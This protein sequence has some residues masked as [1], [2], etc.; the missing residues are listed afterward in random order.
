MLPKLYMTEQKDDPFFK[1]LADFRRRQ[2]IALLLERSQTT[3]EICD[4]F[5]DSLERT[6]VLKHLK[7]LQQAELILSERKGRE[8]WN[9]FNKAIFNKNSE[10]FISIY[11]ANK[12]TLPKSENI[13]L[14][15]QSQQNA[16]PI[17]KDWSVR[18]VKKLEE[19]LHVLYLSKDLKTV[20]SRRHFFTPENV[21]DRDKHYS[22][23][24][25][26]MLNNL[27]PLF[28]LIKSEIYLYGEY[29]YISLP[30]DPT[31][32]KVLDDERFTLPSATDHA[33]LSLVRRAL[34]LR[35]ALGM[36]S[37][38]AHL[39]W[40]RYPEGN[41]LI[42]SSIYSIMKDPGRGV[43]A[44]KLDKL[45]GDKGMVLC[46]EFGLNTLDDASKW[47]N[48]IM[49]EAREIAKNIDPELTFVANNAISVLHN[50]IRA[51][52][53]YKQSS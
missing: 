19:N 2:M 40:R 38:V 21:I 5:K 7:V 46:E 1:A 4:H 27:S 9:R 22:I 52:I 50:T 30:V 20:Y 39:R 3:G 29:L 14:P 51:Y 41:A 16:Q 6:T 53:G 15:T 11:N 34:L 28:G 42:S 17:P 37:R 47:R 18:R 33:Q 35:W 44:A 32:N 31:T 25:T 12:K 13:A 8:V 26:W 23:K 36:P 24:I 43:V 10:Y 48:K 49:E 45:I